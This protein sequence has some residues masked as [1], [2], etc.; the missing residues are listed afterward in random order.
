MVWISIKIKESLKLKLD[1]IKGTR[2]YNTVIEEM[3]FKKFD[4]LDIIL[5]NEKAIKEL[6]KRMKQIAKAVGKG[7]DEYD[8]DPD[9]WII[10][11]K[12]LENTAKTESVQKF[13]KEEKPFKRA[14][15]L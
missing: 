2:S 6:I 7:S 15:E 10:E 11:E 9:E 1:A 5:K 14:D 3:V 4:K 8:F 13:P 12:K